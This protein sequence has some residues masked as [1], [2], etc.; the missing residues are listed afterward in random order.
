MKH[1]LEDA[2]HLMSNTESDLELFF[3][4]YLDCEQRMTEDEVANTILGLQMIHRIRR[5]K[6]WDCY[7]R[8]EKLD[9]YATPEKLAYREALL[10][11]MRKAVDDAEATKK[12]KKKKK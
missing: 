11:G 4:Y 1:N 6:L 9:K 2:I 10:N 5:E 3:E 12:P 7:I 8:H